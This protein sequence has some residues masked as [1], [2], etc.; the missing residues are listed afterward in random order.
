MSDNF[1]LADFR[2]CIIASLLKQG[3]LFDRPCVMNADDFVNQRAV[4][5]LRCKRTT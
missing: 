1:G 2:L 4:V 3:G 5:L